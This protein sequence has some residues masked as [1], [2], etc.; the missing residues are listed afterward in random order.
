MSFIDGIGD[1]KKVRKSSR[2]IQVGKI[3]MRAL[4]LNALIKSKKKM[5][6]PRDM[7]VVK[8]LEAIKKL[9]TNN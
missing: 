5:N 4:S 1:Y 8:E 3:K 9:N 2:M 7:D 6:R